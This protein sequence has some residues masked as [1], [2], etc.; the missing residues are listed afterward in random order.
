MDFKGQALAERIYQILLL[1]AAIIAFTIGYYTQ[2]FRMTM[3]ILGVACV[4]VCAICL[5]DWP[6]FNQHNLNWRPGKQSLRRE[7]D[8]TKSSQGSQANTPKKN[9][10]AK[11]AK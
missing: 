8:T 4:I 3:N 9:K 5:P 1:I 7:M 2:S 6:Y 11:K 10:K